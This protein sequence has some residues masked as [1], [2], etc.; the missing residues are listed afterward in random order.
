MG[1]RGDTRRDSKDERMARYCTSPLG[2]GAYGVYDKAQGKFTDTFSGRG[3][4][5]KASARWR[6]LVEGGDQ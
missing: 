6:E 1:K 4:M 3:A 5:K 2:N